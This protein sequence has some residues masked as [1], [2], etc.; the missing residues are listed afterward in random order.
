MRDA[1]SEPGAML[2]VVGVPRED[3]DA[4]LDGFGDTVWLANDN[5]P[6]QVVLSGKAEAVARLERRL[7]AEGV[8]VRRLRA[9]G[10]FHSPL[11]AGAGEP[12]AEFLSGEEFRPPRIDVYGNADA[13][14]Y[15]ESPGQVRGRLAEHLLSPVRF[16]D[17][18]EAMYK[19]GVRTFVEVGAGAT[20]TGL[21]AEILG[22]RDHLAVS[23][24]RR[25]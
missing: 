4:L 20:L 13:Q 24:D 11:M 2:A 17:G 3:V 25:G 1:S 5:A 19:A 8:T 16:V 23:L 15:P 9:S 12:F 21:A 14:P 6:D 22:D 18:I 7:G 10:A